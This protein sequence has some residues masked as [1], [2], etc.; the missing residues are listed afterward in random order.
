MSAYGDALQTIL[1]DDFSSRLVKSKAHVLYRDYSLVQRKDKLTD[2][3]LHINT[4]RSD[5]SHAAPL[6][7]Y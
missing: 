3:I 1:T 2:K 5:Y 4:L 6:K 7:M